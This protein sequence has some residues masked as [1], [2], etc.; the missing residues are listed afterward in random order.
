MPVF[1]RLAD[2]IIHKAIEEGAF[3]NLA[4][5]GKPVKLKDNP[6]IDP[7]WRLT[8]SLLEKNGFVPDWIETRKDLEERG[9]QAKKSLKRSWEWY[10]GRGQKGEMDDLVEFQWEQAKNKFRREVEEINAA[11]AHLNLEVP[12]AK[13]CL[14]H[15]QFDKELEKNEYG[16]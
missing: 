10:R 7:A 11:I 1:E 3:E 5:H 12:S 13:L 15:I 14:D 6:H 16:D 9:Y 4:G 8:F 2:K